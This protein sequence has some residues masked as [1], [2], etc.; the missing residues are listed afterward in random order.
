MQRAPGRPWRRY[1]FVLLAIMGMVVITSGTSA[2]AAT[3]N[4]H[5]SV[6]LIGDSYTAGN[7]SLAEGP[8]EYY[9]GPAGSYR[10][11]LNWGSLYTD[12][13]NEQGVHARITNLAYG[14]AQTSH[15]AEQIA[16][17][18]DDADLVLLT[19][20]G[21]D[22]N[23]SSI[24]MSCFTTLAAIPGN[25]TM[26][27][28]AI[29][30]ANQLLPTVISR[31][32]AVLDSLDAKLADHAQIVLMGYPLLSQDKLDNLSYAVACPQAVFSGFQGSCLNM[33]DAAQAIRSLGEQAETL[34]RSMVA[35]WDA[36]HA[37]QARY[38]GV[39]ES[40]SGHEP[41]PAITAKNPY[42]WFNEL[43]EAAGRVGA[44]GRTTSLSGEQPVAGS[45]MANFTASVGNDPGGWYHPNAVGHQQLAQQLID[46]V[47]V[48]A[49]V[50]SASGQPFAWIQGPYVTKVGTTL[51]LDARGSY[52]AEGDLARYEWDFDGDGGYDQV[53]TSP[54][55]SHIFSVETDGLIG[56]RVTDQA[57]QQAVA[58][59]GLLVS[60]DGDSTPPEQDN[61]PD[62]AN[63]GQSDS[64]GDRIGD[65]CD[66][67]PGYPWLT[68]GM[69][70]QG[71]Q[72]V[73]IAYVD[74][75]G[76][77]VAVDGMPAGVAGSSG[78]LVGFSEQMAQASV[79]DG[80]AFSSLDNVTS[81]DNDPTVNQT[82]TIHLSSS[83]TDPPTTTTAPPTTTTTPPTTTTTPPTTTT[84]PPTSS[85]PT[86]PTTTQAPPTST[87]PA[88]TD[89]PTAPA[90]TPTPGTTPTPP[91]PTAPATTQ[92]PTAPATTVV[93]PATSQ[94]PTA[95][96]IVPTATPPPTAT[97][98]ST[99]TVPTAAPA[100]PTTPAP[101]PPTT[102][103]VSAP[104]GGLVA[105]PWPIG[106]AV[107]LTSAGGLLLTWANRRRVA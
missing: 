9:F 25:A 75:G 87:T 65:V 22:A 84:T 57:G 71:Q 72:V 92:V 105:K 49:S 81:F 11:H 1:A 2:Q 58:T 45:L 69:I 106:F 67:T 18:P 44:D 102:V 46:T 43:Y 61:C 82:I 91:T 73:E 90:T 7:G 27:I 94:A 38:V 60:D 3:A 107:L 98:T 14:G 52:A 77:P 86:A 21:N 70:A 97:E 101:T 79:P 48:P 30:S 63:H 68:L 47:G 4:R 54:V 41:D 103:T 99:T 10:S 6:V 55:V 93:P 88:T 13:L 40:F 50:G 33:Y 53:T 31:T 23:F 28:N 39:I 78:A 8:G 35:A 26:C 56:L 15:M 83:P 42:R 20:G 51:V 64:D 89:V 17:I 16:A 66:P 76:R 37:R 24:I 74:D 100:P 19:I 96:P 62:V 104:T 34:Q 80:Y 12:W 85:T 29:D 95:P 5:L 36:S 59:T 32:Q